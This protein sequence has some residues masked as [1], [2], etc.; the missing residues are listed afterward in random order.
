MQFKLIFQQVG[1]DKDG[2]IEYAIIDVFQDSGCSHNES[3]MPI[4]EAFFASCYGTKGYKIG[5][6]EILTDKASNGPIRG[7]GM[8][9]L[10]YYDGLCLKIKIDLT[11]LKQVPLRESH[12]TT[13][14]WRELLRNCKKI[15][16][17]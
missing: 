17:K 15:L 13:R 11:K 14:S 4:F 6:N 12:S 8:K 16:W 3:P 1:Y 2:K 5:A 7:P 10:K 9:I